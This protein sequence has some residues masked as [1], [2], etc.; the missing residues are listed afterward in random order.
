MPVSPFSDPNRYQELDS[1]DES[2]HSQGSRPDPELERTRDDIVNSNLPP[3][4]WADDIDEDWFEPDPDSFSRSDEIKIPEFTARDLGLMPD[5]AVDIEKEASIEKHLN[6]S[7]SKEE[8]DK[9][10]A[11]I[12]AERTVESSDEIHS[13]KLYFQQLAYEEGFDPDLI[14]DTL[15]K[16]YN[17]RYIPEWRLP[18]YSIRNYE[19]CTRIICL[20]LQLLQSRGRYIPLLLGVDAFT[21]CLDYV[22][23][24]IDRYGHI[25]EFPMAK[26]LGTLLC[27]KARRIEV[28]QRLLFRSN[29]KSGGFEHKTL[30][31]CVWVK[32]ENPFDYA[33]LNEGDSS[34]AGW[35]KPRVTRAIGQLPSKERGV[36]HIPRDM[37][38]RL[39]KL[40]GK[41]ML[42]I[43]IPNGSRLA[44]IDLVS[45][46]P[47]E[48]YKDQP[49]VR[50][51][52][53]QMHILF[54]SGFLDR[55]SAW[56]KTQTDVVEAWPYARDIAYDVLH[57]LDAIDPRYSLPM[58]SRLAERF[59]PLS[60]IE[61]LVI[62]S[63]HPKASKKK[64]SKKPFSPGGKKGK[65]K[66]KGTSQYG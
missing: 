28:D 6:R 17:K 5:S 51:D 43:G 49:F 16:A 55:F 23:A 32:G 25:D 14:D 13:I 12:I 10:L 29:W 4:F 60:S 65:G 47:E 8:K 44:W 46:R 57:I 41:E 48:P 56:F 63:Q 24:N 40:N 35:K 39:V 54:E 15:L 26:S 36:Y 30:E 38:T 45:K 22:E 3:G 7:L 66:P 18:N 52:R 59:F 34:S 9:R 42:Q 37:I 20:T 61:R 1:D 50:M 53:K 33:L 11:I 21:E 58:M 31:N 19:D 2:G 64:Q 27:Q 62:N